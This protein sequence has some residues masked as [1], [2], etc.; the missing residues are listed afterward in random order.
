MKTKFIGQLFV[1]LTLSACINSQH[2]NMD[3]KD[4]TT[5]EPTVI[6]YKL[7]SN[8][9]KLDIGQIID[10]LDERC[11]IDFFDYYYP[12]I[13]DPGAYVTVHKEDGQLKYE[14]ANHGWSSDWKSINRDSL[15]D[16]IYK[17]REHNNGIISLSARLK[18]KG[19]EKTKK[20]Q[21]FMS[22]FYKIDDK[23]E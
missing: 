13:S 11:A 9:T 23:R 22:Y 17:N 6:E 10:K 15:V 8:S 2:Q 16:Y 18:S 12:Q 7:D 4:I 5:T 14:L 1:I 3:N 19:W 20:G 21:V